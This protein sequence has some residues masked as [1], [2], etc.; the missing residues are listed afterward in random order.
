MSVEFKTPWWLPDGHSQ[1]IWSAKVALP[2]TE[3]VSWARSTW[4]TPDGDVIQVDS[5]FFDQTAPI[6]VLFHGLEGG[7]ESHYAQ[8]FAQVCHEQGWNIVL[9]HFRGCGGPM[10]LAPRAY[11]SG[12][13]QE[14][15]WMLK[16]VRALHPGRTL[17]GV[18]IS[19]GGNALMKWVAETGK[20]AKDTIAAAVA[21]SSPLDL[22]AA[23]KAIDQGVNKWLYAR[24]FLSTMREKAQR[25][26]D[27][28][29][30]LFDLKKAMS[31]TTLEAFDDA[32]TAP[33]HGF[34]GVNDYWKKA[35]AKPVIKQVRIPTLLMNAVNDPFVPARSLPM[36]EEVGSMT[37]V[38]RPHNGGH[39]GFVEPIGPQDWRGHVLAM[40]RAV[41]AWL[42]QRG[43]NG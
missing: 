19:L 10:N 40:P 39:V 41:C 36:Q 42:A 35:S 21:V 8:A 5:R 23:G 31:A 20:E 24:M 7:S 13:F 32:F 15:D 9:P 29:P 1:T 22:V 34:K 33:L 16:R 43:L 17:M 12:D 25:K 18:G 27:Q 3:T 37:T 28:Y 11:H 14:I 6:V 2:T 26:W 30:G 4:S 38:W